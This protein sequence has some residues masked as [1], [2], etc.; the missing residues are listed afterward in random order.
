MRTVILGG[1]HSERDDTVRS[2]ILWSGKPMA[3]PGCTTELVSIDLS[4]SPREE[5][6]PPTA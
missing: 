5:I 3:D 1:G 6:G 4:L 2:E